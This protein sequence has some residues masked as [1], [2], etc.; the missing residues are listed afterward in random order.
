MDE[1]RRYEQRPENTSL[2][3]LRGNERPDG[4]FDTLC[5]KTFGRDL[6]DHNN[7]CQYYKA[8]YTN[9]LGAVFRKFL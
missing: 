6:A 4:T 7:Q 2:I 1:L 5:I 9:W 8:S 3:Y